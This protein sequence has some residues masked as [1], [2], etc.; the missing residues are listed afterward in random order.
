MSLVERRACHSAHCSCRA[1]E[2][3][4]SRVGETEG[5]EAQLKESRG[6]VRELER[7]LKTLRQDSYFVDTVRDKLLKYDH[8]ERRCG[9][10]VEENAVLT[11]ARDN[12]HLLRSVAGSCLRM[13]TACAGPADT[14]CLLSRSAVSV[15]R[16]WRKM[17]L[18]CL[19][20][21]LS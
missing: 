18:D 11:Q 12:Q 9:Q 13:I 14:R 8:L 20:R 1:L 6:R 10:L 21:T 19:S 4:T 7:E 5:L 17:W 2:S 15:C 16:S 3:L